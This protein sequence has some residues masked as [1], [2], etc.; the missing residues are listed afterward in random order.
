MRA[1]RPRPTLADELQ[2]AR[3]RLCAVDVGHRQL[4]GARRGS[5]HGHS[6]APA[7]AAA[8]QASRLG[9]A[10]AAL[11]HQAQ[12]DQVERHRLAVAPVVAAWVL[13][14]V[15]I[16]AR[17]CAPAQAGSEYSRASTSP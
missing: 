1:T 16:D 3:R 7:A 11:V 15:G 14:G 6:R 9:V 12:A 8:Q 10:A 2:V 5:S 4:T 17:R 13:D